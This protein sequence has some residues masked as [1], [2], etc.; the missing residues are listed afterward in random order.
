VSALDVLTEHLGEWVNDLDII[1]QAGLGALAELRQLRAD[2]TPLRARP[3]P[4]HQGLQWRLDERQPVAPPKEP[5]QQRAFPIERTPSGGYKLREQTCWS[6]GGT[7]VLPYRDHLRTEEHR[8]WARRQQTTIVP[9]G[10][11]QDEPTVP[12]SDPKRLVFGDVKVCPRCKG[13]LRPERKDPKGVLVPADTYTHDPNDKE[14]RCVKCG[15]TGVVQ[16]DRV[17]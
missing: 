6:C 15:G 12:L 2:G 11:I 7:Y 8:A 1:D 13:K 4:N 16:L 5:E 17:G 10:S 3:H 14:G 9:V